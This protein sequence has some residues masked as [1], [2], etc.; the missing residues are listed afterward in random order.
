LEPRVGRTL[1]DTL[2][3]DK[4]FLVLDR[5]QRVEPDL[6]VVRGSAAVYAHAP[7]LARVP[8]DLD[9][10]WLGD[11]DDIRRVLAAAAAPNGDGRLETRQ[12]RVVPPPHPLHVALHRADVLVWDA[13]APV[14]RLWVDVSTSPYTV[15]SSLRTVPVA[16][17]AGTTARVATIA[18]VLCEKLWVYHESAEPTRTDLRWTDLFDMLVLLRSSVDLQNTTLRGLALDC[19]Q[20]FVTRGGALPTALGPP[21]R[22]WRSAWA[23]LVGP[24]AR[25]NPTL[26][27]AF[28][29]LHRFWEPVLR[30]GARGGRGGSR[31]WH[32]EPWE[33]R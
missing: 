4:T 18:H 7:S 3:L 32:P 1:V 12:L 17:R 10:F 25:R 31:R 15:P 26:D 23:R 9:V 21:P 30:A 20:Y 29:A 2:Q 13:G 14:H 16:S 5:L 24:V 6:I 33:W 28:G 19:R 11:H 27:A 8:N 22:E